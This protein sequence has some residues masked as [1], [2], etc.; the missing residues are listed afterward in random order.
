MNLNKLEDLTY[1][2][3]NDLNIN[4][5]L[6]IL[7]K[8][9]L[10]MNL[11]TDLITENENVFKMLFKFLNLNTA[12][13]YQ[14]I[15]DLFESITDKPYHSQGSLICDYHLESL[16]SHLIL[17]M[18]YTLNYLPKDMSDK[19]KFYYVFLSLF[20]DCGKPETVYNYYNKFLGYPT[21]S[22]HGALF[23]AKIW[24][25]GLKRYIS[26]DKWEELCNIISLHS[27]SYHFIKGE[28]S[29]QRFDILNILA[30]NNIKKGLYYLSYGDELGKVSSKRI[31]NNSNTFNRF[32]RSILASKS[33]IK[34]IMKDNK[35]KGIVISVYG[36][37]N[38]NIEHNIGKI[39]ESNGIPEDDIGYS[40]NDKKFIIIT[41]DPFNNRCRYKLRIIIYVNEGP[42]ETDLL[43]NR[44]VSE[45]TKYDTHSLNPHFQL[46][47]GQDIGLKSLYK[48]LKKIKK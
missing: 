17:A 23:M 15:N 41:G 39:L 10:L 12:E 40:L 47:I 35:L 38:L 18:L 24:H 45:I 19:D 46:Y 1:Q 37:S 11:P 8:I 6:N 36:G 28:N 43:N 42:S 31:N 7:K 21:H 48:F 26:R 33:S 25:E 27:S 44:L 3:S 4:N 34:S 30:D 5:K 13:P 2:Y 14:K 29:K 22:I 9:C 16:R 20:H 32:Y